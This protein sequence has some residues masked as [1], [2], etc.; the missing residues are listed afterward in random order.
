MKSL[1]KAR[2]LN[3]G[4][5]P[6]GQ[7][8]RLRLLLHRMIRRA[9]SWIS[10]PPLPNAKPI[11]L[12]FGRIDTETRQMSSL[13]LVG[14]ADLLRSLC[15][16]QQRGTR[17]GPR[18]NYPQFP[19]QRASKL[20]FSRASEPATAASLVPERAA[21]LVPKRAAMSVHPSYGL[22]SEYRHRFRSKKQARQE[23]KCSKHCFFA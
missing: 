15:F 13:D 14:I 8:H 18:V 17:L 7:R 9:Q 10:S 3:Y 1:L 20:T 4:T 11:P 22:P 5:K 23:S 2:A 12:R 6:V 16:H 19:A 21:S